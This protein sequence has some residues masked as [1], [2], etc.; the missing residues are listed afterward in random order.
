MFGQGHPSQNHKQFQHHRVFDASKHRRVVL[1]SMVDIYFFVQKKY[2]IAMHIPFQLHE[3][4]NPILNIV[5]FTANRH[6]L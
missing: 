4:A 1:H 2:S 3:T 5:N 6:I